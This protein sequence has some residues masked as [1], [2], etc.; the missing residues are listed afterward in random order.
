ML[1][2]SPVCKSQIYCGIGL[3][4]CYWQLETFQKNPLVSRLDNLFSLWNAPIH[5]NI[6]RC[7]LP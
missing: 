6:F 5:I 7:S 1:F 4:D 2:N 3:S